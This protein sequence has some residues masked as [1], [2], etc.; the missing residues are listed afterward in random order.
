MK[1]IIATFLIVSFIGTLFAQNDYEAFRFSQTE[2]QGTA[3][4]MGAGG[5]FGATG[6]EFSA[7]SINPAAI[8]LYKRNEVTFTPTLLSFSKNNT[9]YYGNNSYT[10][11]P[12]YTLPQCGLVLSWN[13]ENSNWRAW[14][15]GFGYNRIMDFNNTFRAEGIAHNTMM[16]TIIDHVNGTNFN[17]L[18]GDGELAWKTCMID[19]I[20]GFS[21][22]YGTPFYN[23]EIKQEGLVRTFGAIDEMSVTFGG[24][25][26]DQLYL[27]ASIGIPIL[28]FTERISYSEETSDEEALNRGIRSFQTN[29]VQANTGGGINLKLG[30]IYQPI[31]F[32]RCGI[33]FQTPTYYWKI[34]DSYTRDMQSFYTNG[35]HSDF[36]S[37]EN[38]YR[39][40]LTT[41]LKFNVN[42]A[43]LINKRAFVSAEYE[44]T[45]HSMATLYANDYGFTEENEAIRMK[46]RIVHTLRVGG[47]V[48]LGPKFALRGGYNYKTSPYKLVD[49]KYNASAHYASVGFGIRTKYVF[50]DMAYV[51]RIMNDSYWIYENADASNVVHN[52]NVTHRIAA[53]IGCKF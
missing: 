48:N 30:L 34:K 27:G 28:D 16:N 5:A 42:T 33:G 10:Q 53:T 50:F 11:N 15:F 31:N 14:Q 2:Y 26:N 44:L 20:P 19:T 18:A 7:I 9:Q 12:K 8:G 46:Y 25:Y 45:D 32:F 23:A 24:N 6:G 3:R 41:P 21:D 52:S 35:N 39:F 4:F 51:L 49:N 40:S 43:F 47:E 38:E 36:C 13:I 1:K 22:L 17:N 37:Y 29:T